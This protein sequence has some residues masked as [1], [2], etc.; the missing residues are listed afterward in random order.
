MRKQIFLVL[1]SAISL[2]LYSQIEVNPIDTSQFRTLET[3]G[4]M[5]S[6]SG[7]S[8]IIPLIGSIPLLMR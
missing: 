6:A 3:I 8:K 1:F 2:Q 4:M 5:A 7:L